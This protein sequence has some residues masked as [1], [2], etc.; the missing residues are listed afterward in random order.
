MTMRHK[1][2]SMR[3]Q[4]LRID[5]GLTQKAL[6]ARVGCAQSEISRIEQGSR[7]VS[8]ERLQQLATALE[9]PVS[10]LLEDGTSLAA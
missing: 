3:L 9:V 5:A 1:A 7:T 4:A 2:M 10:A 6:A 8:V